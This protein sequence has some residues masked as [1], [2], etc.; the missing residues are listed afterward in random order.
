MRKKIAVFICAISFSNQ[1]RILDGI[2]EEAQKYNT[3]V[4]VFTCQVN[5]SANT[6]D[7][8]GA[9]SVMTLPEFQFFDGAIIMKNSILNEEIAD[10]LIQKIQASNIPAVSISEEIDGMICIKNSN[11]QGQKSVVEHLIEVHQCKKIAYVSGILRTEEGRQRY[12]GYVDAL[13]SHRLKLEEKYIYQGDYIES[14]G[15]KAVHHFLRMGMLPEAIV[16]ANDGMAIGVVSELLNMGYRIPQDVIVTGFDNDEYSRFAVPSMTTVD[17]NQEM[18]GRNALKVLVIGDEEDTLLNIPSRLVIGDSCGCENQNTFTAEELRTEYTTTMGT[19]KLAIDSI[20]NMSLELA[21]VDNL[22]DLYERLK[23]Y[24]V[25]TDMKAFYLCL[26]QS[27]DRLEIPMAYEGGSFGCY[28]SYEKGKVLP[29]QVWKTEKASFYIVTSLFYKDVNFGYIIQRGSHFAFVS[30]LAYSW[31]VNVSN[32]ME[33]IRKLDLM[34]QMVDKLNSMWMYDTLTNLYNRGGFFYMAQDLLVKFR[35][36]QSKCFL[37]FIDLDGLKAIND[38]LGHEYGDQYITSMAEVLRKTFF[39][40]NTICMRYGGDEFVVLGEAESETQAK[41][42]VEKIRENAQLYR[43][44]EQNVQLK[45]S[46]GISVYQANE[47]TDLSV[48]LEEA[49][50]KM[51]LEKKAKRNGETA[52]QVN[53]FSKM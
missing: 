28:G 22:E 38:N 40:K 6:E 26:D 30:D 53:M 16:C 34:K 1:R 11:Y 15:R 4:V 18:I 29:D 2:L 25:N 41:L 39:S 47:I 7:L 21:G 13:E 44:I 48:L 14:S 33:N 46:A 32:A 23:K 12:Q 43:Q 51:Y 17:Q 24:V 37:L 50:Q 42:A 19:M 8:R 31:I 49:D 45:F 20:K 5:H 36:K 52:E 35:N 10:K 27:E 9:F 3:D